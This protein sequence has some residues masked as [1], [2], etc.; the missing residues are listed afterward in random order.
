[1]KFE[2]II[3]WCAAH[4]DEVAF[5]LH[6]LLGRHDKAPV[7]TLVSLTAVAVAEDIHTT[8]ALALTRFGR[9]VAD[10][11]RR[12]RAAPVM[13]DRRRF[14][15]AQGTITDFLVLNLNSV[16]IRVRRTTLGEGMAWG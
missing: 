14:C 11:R 6:Q 3:A 9:M 1:V 5:A 12:M 13:P 7:A 4:P 10:H 15:R 2:R 8:V 16:V